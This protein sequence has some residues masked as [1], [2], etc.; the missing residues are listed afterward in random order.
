MACVL[1]TSH[2]TEFTAESRPD[3]PAERPSSNVR[4]C[5]DPRTKRGIMGVVPE[6]I[7]VP[8]HTQVELPDSEDGFSSSVICRRADGTIK[9]QALPPGGEGDAWVSV[10][11]EGASVVANSWA[12]WR[13]VYDLATGTETERTFTK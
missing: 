9:W 13:V 12:C 2:I 6:P 10:Q 1:V 11:V 5:R 4:L 3:P 8:D 7:L